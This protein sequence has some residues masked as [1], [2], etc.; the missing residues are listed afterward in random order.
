MNLQNQ[1]E[2]GLPKGAGATEFNNQN[3]GSF[4]N[5]LFKATALASIAVA[6]VIIISCGSDGSNGSPGGGGANGVGCDISAREDQSGVD[7]T[8]G[9]QTYFLHNGP[10]GDAGGVGPDGPDCRVEVVPGFY[11]MWCGDE[12]VGVLHNGTDAKGNGCELGT[13]EGTGPGGQDELYIACGGENVFSLSLCEKKTYNKAKQFCSSIPEGLNPSPTLSEDGILLYYCNGEDYVPNEEY[14]ARNLVIESVRKLGTTDFKDVDRTKANSDNWKVL[15]IGDCFYKKGS[16]EVEG[17]CTDFLAASGTYV[18]GTELAEVPAGSGVFTPSPKLGLPI[19]ACAS[20]QL[21]DLAGETCV[22]GD[23]DCQTVLLGDNTCY[24]DDREVPNAQAYAKRCDLDD[25]EIFYDPST[26]SACDASGKTV[27][28]AIVCS[29]ATHFS[30]FLYTHPTNP[31]NGKTIGQRVSC[32]N[33]E[34]PKKC[35]EGSTLL[36]SGADA[37]KCIIDDDEPGCPTGYTWGLKTSGLRTDAN[38]EPGL[39]CVA[40]VTNA[41]CPG[42]AEAGTGDNEGTCVLSAR[43]A[44]FTSG[45][46]YLDSVATGRAGWTVTNATG[47]TNQTVVCPHGGVFGKATAPDNVTVGDGYECLVNPVQTVTATSVRAACPSGSIM[48][49]TSLTNVTA[50]M[51][52]NYAT[53]GKIT[54]TTT[55]VE[56]KAKTKGIRDTSAVAYSEKDNFEWYCVKELVNNS[57]CPNDHY[58][59]VNGWCL[60]NKAT[61]FDHGT[62]VAN[63]ADANY[64]GGAAPN[65]EETMG[66]GFEPMF[67]DRIAV[68]QVSNFPNAAGSGVGAYTVKNYVAQVKLGTGATSSKMYSMQVCARKLQNSDCPAPVVAGGTL[69]SWSLVEARDLGNATSSVVT[70]WTVEAKDAVPP[71]P[72][73]VKSFRYGRTCKLGGAGYAFV[74]PK[75]AN[76]TKEPIKTGATCGFDYDGTNGIGADLCKAKNINYMFSSVTNAC[77][78]DSNAPE[79]PLEQHVDWGAKG[80]VLNS[81][82]SAF[83]V[84][85]IEVAHDLCPLNAGITKEAEFVSD[86]NAD[87]Q[88]CEFNSYKAWN[89]ECEN[90]AWTYNEDTGWCEGS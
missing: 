66:A 7:V 70:G 50:Y 84:C 30:Q 45:A 71:A 67:G 83:R 60:P 75:I 38:D 61:K 74:C 88:K 76:T 19:V 13:S 89:P 12:K 63:F 73:V 4:M 43:N 72:A 40:K 59:A 82:N 20:T 32:V 87:Q 25:G 2:R 34:Q 68:G 47:A 58:L 28:A 41:M 9:N 11:E 1:K 6:S 21:F 44:A 65:C 62:A 53:D 15:D 27:E 8:C 31:M 33:S 64:K 78:L 86:W 77:I 35:P 39:Y 57:D 3:G 55:E 69:S 54:N 18:I 46:P 24:S 14:C 17:L 49:L 56:T 48:V 80:R 29:G 36:T 23:V 81:V 16:V 22:T 10:I 42:D 85:Q 52:L 51:N 37:G 5:K 26:I 90:P 79:C